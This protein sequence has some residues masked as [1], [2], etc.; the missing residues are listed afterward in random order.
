MPNWVKGKL[1][2]QGKN[3]SD[4][5]K[6]LLIKGEDDEMKFDFNK[7]IPMPQEL[8]IISGSITTQCVNI[9]YT[10]LNPDV[11]DI[12][13]GNK[14]Q[15]EFD[16]ATALLSK[17]RFRTYNAKVKNKEV[18]EFLD[19]NY[20]K[21]EKIISIRDA[22]D[23]GKKAVSNIEKYG[24]M[25][26]YD[27]CTA[28]WGTKWNACHN[29]FYEDSPNEIEFDTA[30]GDVRH[31]ILELSKQYPENTFTYEYSEEQIGLYTGFAICENGKIQDVQFQDCSKDAYEMAFK[32]WG[33]GCSECF[34]FNETTNTYDF[35]DDEEMD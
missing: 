12:D 8:N 13:L 6:A 24:T 19:T 22:V 14:N 21:E 10:S 17:T 33:E 27:W 31:L 26:W 16:K 25:D 35:I 32:L 18:E 11:E 4:V 30:W 28:N 29:E 3:S 34:K 20:A 15:E 2:I 23:Y 7:I 9:Y 5:M 1:T